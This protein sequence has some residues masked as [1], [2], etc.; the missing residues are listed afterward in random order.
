MFGYAFLKVFS[1]K[2]Q[3]AK[4]NSEKKNWLLDC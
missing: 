2:K 3:K 4:T 1:A